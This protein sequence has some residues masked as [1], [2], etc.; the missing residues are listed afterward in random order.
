MQIKQG[1]QVT[2]NKVC[3]ALLLKILK[4]CRHTTKLWTEGVPFF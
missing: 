2:A 4:I 1:G 3:C